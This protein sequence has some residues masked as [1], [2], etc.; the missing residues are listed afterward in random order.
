MVHSGP[1]AMIIP[2]DYSHCDLFAVLIRCDCNN[3]VTESWIRW[4]I[5]CSRSGKGCKNVNETS[6][7]SDMSNSGYIPDMR[8]FHLRSTPIIWVI[9]S[10]YIIYLPSSEYFTS[11]N[12]RVNHYHMLQHYRVCSLSTDIQYCTTPFASVWCLFFVYFCNSKRRWYI[13]LGVLCVK[14]KTMFEIK[15]CL[16]KKMRALCS[17]Q[18]WKFVCLLCYFPMT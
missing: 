10:D 1:V 14:K 9:L 18:Y 2:L 4:L 16:A 12:A 11:E 17:K 5:T 15:M 7:T 6:V 8:P 13:L 3:R